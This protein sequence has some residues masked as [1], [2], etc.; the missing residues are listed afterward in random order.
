MKLQEAPRVDRLLAVRD[1]VDRYGVGASTVRKLVCDGCLK[2]VRLVP[3]GRLRLRERDVQQFIHS[4]AVCE[5]S[6]LLLFVLSTRCCL[7]R[8]HADGR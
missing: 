8:T 3:G 5:W 7:A 4:A 2:P 6:C 1:V